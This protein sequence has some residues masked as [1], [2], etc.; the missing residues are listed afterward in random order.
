MVLRGHVH[1]PGRAVDP[2]QRAAAWRIEEQDGRHRFIRR[3][4][5]PQGLLN[6]RPQPGALPDRIAIGA[7][8]RRLAQSRRGSRSHH[9]P[10]AI[11]DMLYLSGEGR[12]QLC[13]CW[14]EDLRMLRRSGISRADLTCWGYF[15]CRQRQGILFFVV[16]ATESRP[17][18][19]GIGGWDGGPKG[20]DKVDDLDTIWSRC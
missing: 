17:A 2:E 8:N 4:L 19:L 7:I 11:K 1:G 10:Y 16:L 13:R 14:L 15:H 9:V 18:R 20:A 6:H 5:W 3:E 12:I